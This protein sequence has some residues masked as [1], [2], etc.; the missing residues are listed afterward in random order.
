MADKKLK[1]AAELCSYVDEND[2]NLNLEI[3]LPGVK[4]EDIHLRML[5][6][7]FYLTAPRDDFEYV[8]TAAFCCP[9]EAKS[10]DATY[11]DGML[12][13]SVP[14]KDPMS[15]AHRVQIH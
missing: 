7:S 12:K 11:E 3:C 6:D 10:A 5:E 1:M 15:D 9:V 2:N 14:F 13:V 8:S 4:K